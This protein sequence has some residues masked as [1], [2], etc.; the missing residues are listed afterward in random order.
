LFFLIR[1]CLFIFSPAY[2]GSSP[3]EKA[4]EKKK[5]TTDAVSGL[6]LIVLFFLYDGVQQLLYVRF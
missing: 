1:W 2:V 5:K 3:P 6:K 4:A